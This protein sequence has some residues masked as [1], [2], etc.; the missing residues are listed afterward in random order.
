MSRVNDQ[1][2]KV[3][4]VLDEQTKL[5]PKGSV[6]QLKVELFDD[7]PNY[8][9]LLE[10]LEQEHKLITIEQRP[11]ERGLSEPDHGMFEM[12]QPK[13]YARYMSYSLKIKPEFSKFYKDQYLKHRFTLQSLTAKNVREVLYVMREVDD[14][15]SITGNT[16]VSFTP[17]GQDID[18]KKV[19]DF[20]KKRGAIESH[21][22]TF[23]QGNYILTVKVALPAFDDLLTELASKKA[24]DEQP[25]HNDEVAEKDAATPEQERVVMFMA[26]IAKAFGNS[27]QKP[28]TLPLEAFKPLNFKQVNELVDQFASNKTFIVK[29][30]PKTAS[31]KAPF[32]FTLTAHQKTAFNKLKNDMAYL[33]DIQMLMIYWGKLCEVYDAISSGYVGFD[34]GLLNR[35]Y[36]LLTLRMD[37]IFA[38]D[39]FA[40]LREEKPFIY[41]SFMGNIDDLDTAYEFMRPGLWG[42][43]GKLERL[44]VEKADGLGAFNLEED[45]QQLLNDTDKAITEHKK[46]KARLN[47]NFERHLE[48]AAAKYNN[49]KEPTANSKSD[50]DGAPI[51]YDDEHGKVTYKGKSAAL[52][53]PEQIEGFLFYRIHKA[54][55]ARINAAD[56]ASDY[57]AKHPELDKDVTTKTLTNAKDRINKK[58]Q[59]TFGITAAVQYE[60][61]SFW[62][63][64][65]YCS[66]QS[67]YKTASSGN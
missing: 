19:L 52:L 54:D 43:Y 55:G 11:D 8:E 62:L 41:D 32:V 15:M 10:K 30:R 44:W 42:F 13:N 65:K 40:E 50:D 1:L 51:G 27:E 63:Q 24:N 6:M 34:D 49:G 39:S 37:K 66:E 20:L 22:S 48:T 57:E 38:K 28:V 9:P 12:E 14:D 35:S 26:V 58:L 61:Q 59:N 53:M 18:Y 3:M 21:S 25:E 5:N 46:E 60:R 33:R 2:L 56:I 7:C 45:E 4:S 16:E 17:E 23:R 64:E 47:A 36:L 29:S 67:P 31:D